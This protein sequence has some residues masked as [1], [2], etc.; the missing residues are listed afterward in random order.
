MPGLDYN[1]AIMAERLA[2]RIKTIAAGMGKRFAAPML[3][4]TPMP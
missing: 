4:L 2:Q 1:R 3:A